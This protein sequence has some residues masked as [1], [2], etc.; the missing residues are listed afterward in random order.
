MVILWVE[1]YYPFVPSYIPDWIEPD[2]S[3]RQIKKIRTSLSFKK[4]AMWWLHYLVSNP[5]HTMH[6]QEEKPDA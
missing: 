1:G 5:E 3:G 4:R 6:I 2:V